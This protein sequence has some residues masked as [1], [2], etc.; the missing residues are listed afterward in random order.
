MSSTI[1]SL[2]VPCNL[3]V[4]FFNSLEEHCLYVK[5]MKPV[6]QSYK[7]TRTHDGSLETLFLKAPDLTSAER[8][9]ALRD[10][11]WREMQRGEELNALIDMTQGVSS[12]CNKIGDD[13][14][15]PRFVGA[16][17]I[18]SVTVKKDRREMIYEW[19]GMPFI[20]YKWL[21]GR[22]LDHVVYEGKKDALTL[23]AN[24]FSFARGITRVVKRL[25]NSE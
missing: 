14:E 5:E 16:G 20:L 23:R 18:L 9:D 25:H 15:L 2:P 6:G 24:W 1:N 17:V 11:F 19:D 7:A 21:E 12:T 22:Q 10:R 4:R 8:R 13:F 3:K